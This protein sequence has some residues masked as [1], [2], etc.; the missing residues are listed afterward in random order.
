MTPAAS[1]PRAVRTL[2]HYCPERSCP[3]YGWLGRGNI[4]ANGHPNSQRWRQWHCLACGR[5]CLETH[6]TLFH[7]KTR[8]AQEILRAIAALAEGLGLRVVARVFEV[9]PN[10]VLSWLIEAADHAEALSRYLLH[11]LNIEQVQLDELFALVSD[12]NDERRGQVF[13]AIRSRLKAISVK[14]PGLY[15]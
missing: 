3:Y 5:Y 2:N 13:L 4:R 15:N 6:G 10:T 11:D 12:V 14:K 7:G 8:A 1:R 9:E